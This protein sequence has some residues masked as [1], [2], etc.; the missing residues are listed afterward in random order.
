MDGG[1][2]EL[3]SEEAVTLWAR[4]AVESGIDEPFVAARRG[5]AP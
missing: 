3:T 5:T 2:R 4:A 1:R